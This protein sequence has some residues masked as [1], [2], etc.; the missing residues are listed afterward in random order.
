MIVRS[1]F[2]KD[3]EGLLQLYAHLRNDEHIPKLDSNTVSMWQRILS[4]QN[5]QVIVAE[6]ENILVATCSITIVP[7]LTRGV[8]PYAILENVVTDRRFRRQGFARAC[9]E[10]AIELAM[11]A[12]CYKIMLTTGLSNNVAHELYKKT[13]FLENERQAYVLWL[14]AK[15]EDPESHKAL[16]ESLSIPDNG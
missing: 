16:C 4:T 7:N 15:T 6:N 8:R 13:G 11:E 5:H 10:Y 12:N 1:V 3:L 9:I 14:S 2:E